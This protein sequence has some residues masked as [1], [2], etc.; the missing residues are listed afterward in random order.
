MWDHSSDAGGSASSSERSDETFTTI[1]ANGESALSPS[2]IFASE[3]EQLGEAL[4]E[5]GSSGS[6][7]VNPD[8]ESTSD[9][10]S[11]SSSEWVGDE[12]FATF[13]TNAENPFSSSD[14]PYSSSEPGSPSSTSS[15][16][17]DWPQGDGWASLA[18]G[19]EELFGNVYAHDN[20]YL[21]AA[22]QSAFGGI[23][24][25]AGAEADDRETLSSVYDMSEAVSVSDGSR[26]TSD[27]GLGR[28]F[29]DDSSSNTSV[30]D[31]ADIEDKKPTI[32]HMY[33]AGESNAS[34]AVG[35]VEAVVPMTTASAPGA[36]P[37]PRTVPSGASNK[38]VKEELIC[39]HDKLV[40]DLQ[41]SVHRRKF[42]LAWEDVE[43]L[44]TNSSKTI[45]Q[46]GPRPIRLTHAGGVFS[47]PR[48]KTRRG[49]PKD[50]DKYT[51]SGGKAG[52]TQWPSA[53]DARL[54]RKY[55]KARVDDGQDYI[56]VHQYSF[57]PNVID[58]NS[59]A[60]IVIWH[61]PPWGKAFSIRAVAFPNKIYSR[62]RKS[63]EEAAADASMPPSPKRKQ[64]SASLM[65][66]GLALT[67]ALI[68][69]ALLKDRS[70]WH[71]PDIA[72]RGCKRCGDR[73]GFE[74]QPCRQTELPFGDT[75]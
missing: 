71:R 8:D 36:N 4:D 45:E 73:H 24:S 26:D 50:S 66:G 41:S 44:L 30:T 72:P 3:W 75:M 43:L 56:S 35:K 17:M 37:R 51:N 18:V 55:F 19:K 67:I 46:L 28:L 29:G 58:P 22:H 48:K 60:D 38:V 53:A 39:D 70:H 11:P 9:P 14:S 32:A 2:N 34:K 23:S 16:T 6:W 61:V 15:S 12:P 40:R 54:Q 27:D 21:N 59:D 64:F 62:K 25:W 69:T 52:A 42:H 65:A 57:A 31:I 63:E 74:I 7:D 33:A 13:N 1:S 20:P 10:L 47:E 5:G 68:C 49:L